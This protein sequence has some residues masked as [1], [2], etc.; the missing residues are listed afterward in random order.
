MAFAYDTYTNPSKNNGVLRATLT[1]FLYSWLLQV[2]LHAADTKPNILLTVTDDLGYR[3]LGLY[4]A[5]KTKTPRI[6]VLASKSVRFTAS[7]STHEFAIHGITRPASAPNGF[8]LSSICPV[9]SPTGVAR[10]G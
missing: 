1:S 7:Y 10:R 3:D 2:A 6:E 8:L 5:T 9:L 4:V